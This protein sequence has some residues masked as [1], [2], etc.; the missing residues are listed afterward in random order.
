MSDIALTF[1]VNAAVARRESLLRRN[2]AKL[3]I[4]VIKD[5]NFYCPQR[6]GTLQA[7]AVIHSNIGSGVIRWVTPYARRLY[8]NPQYHFSKDKNPNARGKWFEEAKARH[9]GA[10]LDI[11]KAGV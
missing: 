3:D 10:W 4:Q 6:E 7:S 5:S 9:L 1:D 11:A 2:Q 8:Y